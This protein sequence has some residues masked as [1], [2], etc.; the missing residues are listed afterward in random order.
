MRKAF[1]DRVDALIW[2]IRKKELELQG[3]PYILGHI[4]DSHQFLQHAMVKI[5]VS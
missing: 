2:Q 3:E 5:C 4:F 1:E